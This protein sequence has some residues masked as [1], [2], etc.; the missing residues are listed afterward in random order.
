MNTT[1]R[2]VILGALFGAGSIGLRALATGLP[3]SILLNPRASLAEACADRE[4][5]QFLI[6]ATSGSGDPAN[7]NMPGTYDDPGIAHPQDAAMM[8]TPMMLS[9]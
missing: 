4:R 7:A 2:E 1:R 8:P 9:G 5:A 6:W 3:A